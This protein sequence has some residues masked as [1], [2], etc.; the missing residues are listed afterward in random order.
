MKMLGLELQN[1]VPTMNQ[2]FRKTNDNVYETVNEKNIRL[3]L[4]QN[5]VIDSEGNIQ[6]DYYC[7]KSWFVKWNDNEKRILIHFLDSCE[8]KTTWWEIIYH[9]HKWVFPNRDMYDISCQMENVIGIYGLNDVYN[10]GDK[11]NWKC[12]LQKKKNDMNCFFSLYLNCD[13]KNFYLVGQT[14][15]IIEETEYKQVWIVKECEVKKTK[16]DHT[17]EFKKRKNKQYMTI[18]ASQVTKDKLYWLIPDPMDNVTPEIVNKMIVLLDWKHSCWDVK[19]YCKHEMKIKQC[20]FFLVSVQ[21]P[22]LPKLLVYLKNFGFSLKETILVWPTKNCEILCVENNYFVCHGF[23]LFFF[24]KNPKAFPKKAK[25]KYGNIWC[26]SQKNDNFVL[27]EELQN[28]FVNFGKML[29][30]SNE[31]CEFIVV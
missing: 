22:L 10:C 19:N 21:E 28:L 18:T 6:S 12:I 27:N 30:C 5:G 1:Y 11:F 15:K 25:Q 26:F 9:M 13:Y 29:G 2:L 17:N 20:D 31:N 3:Q 23:T 7:N 16:D 24:L 4:C 8:N 14:R